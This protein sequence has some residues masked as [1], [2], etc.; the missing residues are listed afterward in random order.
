MSI[1]HSVSV[2]KTEQSI[3]LENVISPQSRLEMFT[4]SEK[5]SVT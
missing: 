4:V 3:E 2:Y 5:K 1:V